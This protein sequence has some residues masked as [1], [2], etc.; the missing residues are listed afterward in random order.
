MTEKRQDGPQGRRVARLAGILAAICALAAALYATGH[1]VLG[2]VAAVFAAGFA[3]ACWGVG[4]LMVQVALRPVS[5]KQGGGSASASLVSA[6]SG[7]LLGGP[8]SSEASEEVAAEARADL[9]RRGIDAGDPAQRA[10]DRAV[11]PM[12]SLL[13]PM[14]AEFGELLGAGRRAELRAL[15]LEERRLTAAWLEEA[16]PWQD[17]RVEADDGA[18]LAGHVIEARDGAGRWAVLAHGYRGSWRETIQYARRWALMGYS[19]LLVEQRAHG[20]SGGGLV[21]MG[22]LEGRDLAAWCRWLER[23]RGASSIVLHGHSMGGA[24][25]CMAS[26]EPGLPSCVAAA[27]SDCAYSS[28]W[29]AFEGLLAASGTPAHPTLDLMRL[30]LKAARGGYDIADADPR[31]ALSKPGLPVLL[32]HGEQDPSVAPAMAGELFEAARAGGRRCDLVMVPG[33]GHCQSALAAGA[34]YFS[35]IASFLEG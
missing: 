15:R 24:S 26:A 7:A 13:P 9:E 1:W 5:R 28:A 20:A 10:T 29:G 3:L 11:G 21:G 8:G 18:L 31:R 19:L 4:S 22:L 27:V 33:A 16:G 6:V 2:T 12:L 34:S 25:V 32:F 30:R 35:R 23:E 14:E 17:A